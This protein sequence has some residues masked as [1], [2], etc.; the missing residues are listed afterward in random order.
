MAMPSLGRLL[1][2][3]TS[4]DLGWVLDEVN[5][6]IATKHAVS[7][8]AI[9]PSTVQISPH[10]TRTKGVFGGVLQELAG[11]TAGEERYPMLFHCT[12]GKDRTGFMAA[13]ILLALGVSEDSIMEDYLDT[14]KFNHAWRTKYTR[15]IT[16]VSLGT[17]DVKAF[18]PLFGVERRYLASAFAAIRQEAGGIEKYLRV[19]LGLGDDAQKILRDRFLE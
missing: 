12:A 8:S 16:L 14:N 6:N 1:G 7:V 13:V 2:Q 4:P 11:P 19:N 9:R 3:S 10:P 15:L 17:A 5:I 18:S